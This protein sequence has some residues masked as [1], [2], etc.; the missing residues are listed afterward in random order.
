MCGCVALLLWLALL[1]I[2]MIV[3]QLSYSDSDVKACFASIVKGYRNYV[4]LLGFHAVVSLAALVL[5][6]LFLLPLFIMALTYN[7]YS[8]SLALGEDVTM[9][10]SFQ[11]LA[12]AAYVFGTYFAL[13]VSAACK[14]MHATM[15]GSLES[16]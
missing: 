2:D 15:W 4:Q 3:M 11:W 9:P 7:D 14:V 16:R 1:P 6:A 8:T 5:V 13:H 10:D 12:L